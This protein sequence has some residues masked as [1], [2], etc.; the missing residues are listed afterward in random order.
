MSA[1]MLM[2]CWWCVKLQHSSNVS[3]VVD[4]N[5]N[6]AP[7]FVVIC[8]ATLLWILLYQ[9][10]APS[11]CCTTCTVCANVGYTRCFGGTSVYG[12]HL[13]CRTSQYHRTFILLSVSNHTYKIT[14]VQNLI[15]LG[16]QHRIKIILS[17]ETPWTLYNNI[18]LKETQHMVP[19]INGAMGRKT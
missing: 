7:M 10:S 6:I 8:C 11:W 13:R 3:C 19:N 12:I 4:V 5:C 2:W 9:Y 16:R 17:P 18:Y 15:Y 1:V 14:E